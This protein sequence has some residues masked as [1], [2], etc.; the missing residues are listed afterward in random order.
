MAGFFTFGFPSEFRDGT[1]GLAVTQLLVQNRR[2]DHVFGGSTDRAVE[3]FG[4]QRLAA[5]KVFRGR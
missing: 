5:G 3:R 2:S 1:N 4:N